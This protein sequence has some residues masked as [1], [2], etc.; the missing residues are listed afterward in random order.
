MIRINQSKYYYHPYIKYDRCNSCSWFSA[1]SIENF[2]TTW[3]KRDCR[4]AWG[5]SGRRC[6]RKQRCCARYCRPIFFHTH[7]HRFK[8]WWKLNIDRD[9]IGFTLGRRA[10]VFH[11]YQCYDGGDVG[12]STGKAW[13]LG[14]IE[15]T[16]LITM[17]AYDRPRLDTEIMPRRDLLESREEIPANVIS[18]QPVI[19]WSMIFR[20]TASPSFVRKLI[21]RARG[22]IFLLFLSAERPKRDFVRWG[23][24]RRIFW[25]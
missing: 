20:T 8:G 4:K 19:A 24:K 2:D 7:T 11:K 1:Q 14:G 22:R 18:S 10:A 12:N 15:R 9:Q 6:S 3:L 21:P 16:R 5:I 13:S 23:R 25:F 17:P